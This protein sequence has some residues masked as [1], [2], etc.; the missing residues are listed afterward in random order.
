MIPE[1]INQVSAGFL[2][3]FKGPAKTQPRLRFGNR[4]QLKAKIFHVLSK[5]VVLALK[6]V[7]HRFQL[8]NV[9][10]QKREDDLLFDPDVL[11]ELVPQEIEDLFGLPEVFPERGFSLKTE[12]EKGLLKLGNFLKG[13]GMASFEEADD[14]LRGLAFFGILFELNHGGDSIDRRVPRQ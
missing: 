12:I 3:P 10:A 5:L 14:F 1:K 11:H 2:R 13:V 6:E 4:F 7:D 8:G 9:G